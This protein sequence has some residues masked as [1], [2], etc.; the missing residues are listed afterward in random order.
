MGKGDKRKAAAA[1]DDDEPVCYGNGTIMKCVR[2]DK[3]S[4]PTLPFVSLPV[5]LRPLF[6]VNKYVCLRPIN[7]F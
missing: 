5:A 2:D 1:L 6:F 7:R 4:T 3:A